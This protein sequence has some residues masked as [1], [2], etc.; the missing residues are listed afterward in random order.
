[1]K[2]HNIN[3]VRCS[4]YPA[5][6]YLYDLCDEYGLYV[7]DEADLECHGFEWTGNYKWITDDPEWE[8]SYVDRSVRMVKR[9]RNH[10]C[11]IMW[12]MGNESSLDIIFAVQQKPFVNWMIQDL[13]IMRETLRQKCRMFTLRCT[14][15]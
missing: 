8:K 1:M 14:Q 6:E 15:D 5:N 9:D 3:A 10:P 12:S 13:Y 2:Q 11:I 7:I 4:H